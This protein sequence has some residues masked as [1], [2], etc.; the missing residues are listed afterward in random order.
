VPTCQAL[1]LN[2]PDTVSVLHFRT[3]LEAEEIAD[4]LAGRD[5]DGGG[6]GGG[7]AALSGVVNFPGDAQ[8]ETI[9]DG[10]A[11]NQ[12]QYLWLLQPN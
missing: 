2:H 5:D 9:E 11:W 3:Q 7:G 4:D 6:A 12:P 1:G 8:R 10:S